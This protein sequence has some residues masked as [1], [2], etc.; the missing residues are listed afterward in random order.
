LIDDL[1]PAVDALDLDQSIV[2]NLHRASQAADQIF[3]EAVGQGRITPRQ[4]VVLMTLAR[5]NGISQSDIVDATGIDRSTLADIMRRL[6]DRGLVA[7]RRSR[8][9]ARAYTVRLTPSGL[10]VLEGAA[11]PYLEVEARLRALV[12]QSK[13]ADVMA[14]LATI[15]GLVP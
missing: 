5:R 3:A 10:A 1:S 13:R 15:S 6:L 4:F 2:H 11:Q 7:R 14:A 12:P 8:V 9:D